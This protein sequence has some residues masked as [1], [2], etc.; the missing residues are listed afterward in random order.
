[1]MC[2]EVGALGLGFTA[3]S[4]KLAVALGE[5]LLGMHMKG[6]D[7][8]SKRKALVEN[9]SRQFYAHAYPVSRTEAL[10]M[11][12][13]VNKTR[14]ETFE[15]LIWKLWLDIED[16]FQ[17][18]RPF[19]PLLELF[20]GGHDE[21]VKPLLSSV[22]QWIMPANLPIQNILQTN[23]KDLESTL[24]GGKHRQFDPIAFM[25]V[26]GIMESCR[27]AYRFESRGKILASRMPDLSVQFS[28]IPTLQNWVKVSK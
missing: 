21:A 10:E 19:H 4:S 23:A 6:G 22:P 5:K 9:L 13:A 7:Q 2:K 16:E 15:D 8:D 1:M 3:R 14:D 25:I 27:L 17:E 18:R 20:G 28:C 26:S 24:T 11:G 12:L